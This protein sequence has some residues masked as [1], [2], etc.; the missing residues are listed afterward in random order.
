M[1]L[2][3][4]A[5]SAALQAA[6]LCSDVV[7]E[8]EPSVNYDEVALADP[9]LAEIHGRDLPLV[10]LDQLA[11]AENANAVPIPAMSGFLANTAREMVDNWNNQVAVS[12][13]ASATDASRL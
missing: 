9:E 5:C 4:M 10:G 8:Q 12:L 11:A 13:I 3:T 6:S 1:S 2:M 7:P